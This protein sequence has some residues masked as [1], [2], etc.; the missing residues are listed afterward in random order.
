[1]KLQFPF[2]ACCQLRTFQAHCLPMHGSE[3]MAAQISAETKNYKFPCDHFGCCSRSPYHR[4][5]LALHAALMQKLSA[6]PSELQSGD[7]LLQIVNQVDEPLEP[8]V[9]LFALVVS[10]LQ[11]PARSILVMLTQNGEHP[12]GRM[13]S[14]CT[15]RDFVIDETRSFCSRL[16]SQADRWEFQVLSFEHCS[17]NVVRVVSEKTLFQPGPGLADLSLHAATLSE[18]HE[19]VV[20]ERYIPA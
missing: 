2:F 17:L 1:M 18:M 7:I 16:V 10:H 8:A 3:K 6:F 12:G 9:P 19:S 4:A 11:K 5:A 13:L 14:I 15:S 20:T